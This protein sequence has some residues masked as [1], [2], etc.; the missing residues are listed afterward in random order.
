MESYLRSTEIIDWEHAS[1]L[2]KAKEIAGSSVDVSEI[3]KACFEWVR[4]EIRHTVDY[5]L[6]AVTCRASEV[7]KAGTGFCYAKSH[8]LGALLRANHIPAGFCYQRT[9]LDE[10]KGTYCL[11]GLNAL[12]LPQIGWHRID[13]RGNKEGVDTQ[14]TPPVE[15]LAFDI[16]L[17]GEA[18][19]PEIWPDP[20]PIVLDVLQRFENSEEVANNLPDILII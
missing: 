4:D 12:H 19:L 11:H 10:Q 14:F 17:K 7:L 18:N 3:A 6:P 16:R 9:I 20:L 5:D 15:A 13:P 2:A 1:V 8:L